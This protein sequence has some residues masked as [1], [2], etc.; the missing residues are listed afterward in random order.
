MTEGFRD[1]LLAMGARFGPLVAREELLDFGGPE[2]EYEALRSAAVLLDLSDRGKLD[3]LGG[4]RARFL[5]GQVSN[6]VLALKPGEGCRAALLDR[7]SHVLAELR[8]YAL[9]DRIEVDLD[10]C[11]LDRTVQR[12]ARYV[13]ASDVQLRDRT[14]ELGL[15]SIQ[16][17]LALAV[18]ERLTGASAIGLAEYGHLGAAFQRHP[19]RL[20]RSSRAGGLGVDILHPA[21]ASLL[22]WRALVE[23]GAAPAGMTAV[24]AARIE[25]GIPRYGADVTECHLVQEAAYPDAVS[26]TKGCYTGQE[27]VARVRSRGHVNRLRCGLVV[28]GSALP[29]DEVRAEGQRIGEVTSSARSP[30][31]E[32]TVCQATLKARWAQTDGAAITVHGRDGEAAGRVSAFPMG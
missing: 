10:R 17:P 31:L 23:A 9:E 24:E 13:L 8:V 3:V 7:Q 1:L 14:A 11:A 21:G 5:N 26:F 2:R 32:A 15:F 27:V 28:D 6:D 20:R 29:G 18:A 19:V 22:L 25:A 4:D 12:L 30:R 16:G